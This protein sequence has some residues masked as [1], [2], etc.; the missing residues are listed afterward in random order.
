[1]KIA[2]P[3]SNSA[4]RDIVIRLA[5]GAFAALFAQQCLYFRPLPQLQGSFRPIAATRNP[6]SAPSASNVNGSTR[7]PRTRTPQWR[8]GPV[9]RPVAPAKPTIAPRSTMSPSRT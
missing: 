6:H 7:A 9:T 2:P 8:W 5:R 4:I 1:M 3:S